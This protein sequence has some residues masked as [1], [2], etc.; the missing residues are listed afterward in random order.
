MTMCNV[1]DVAHS[2]KPTEIYHL[3]AV[4]LSYMGLFR[5]FQFI[6]LL[7]RPAI[8]MFL[9]TLMA[10]ISDVSGS[11]THICI[12]VQ[13]HLAAKEPDIPLR[14]WWRPKTEPVESTIWT[15]TRQVAI[16]SK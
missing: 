1:K 11:N 7:L 9:F 16:T 10:F 8:C 4:A 3:T 13:L 6:V 14:S 2:D 15:D 5:V 12:C